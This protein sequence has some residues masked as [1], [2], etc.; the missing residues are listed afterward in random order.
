MKLKKLSKITKVLKRNKFKYV[1]LDTLVP[2]D[3]INQKSSDNFRHLMFTFNNYNTAWALRP[4]LTLM[5]LARYVSNK[6]KKREKI[7]YEGSVFRQRE[8]NKKPI[9]DQCGFEIIGSKNEKKDDAEVIDVAIKMIN[10]L[11]IKS[12]K[13]I[14][15]NTNIFKEFLYGI[16]D[17]NERWA[18][19][20]YKNFNNKE[21]FNELLLRLETSNDLD[22]KVIKHDTK[23]YQK[24]KNLDKNLVIGR[25]KIKDIISRFEKK[26]I[27]DPR[28][29]DQGKKISKLIRDFIIISKSPLKDVEKK[30]IKFFKSNKIKINLNYIFPKNLQRVNN[31]K[32][33]F[34]NFRTLDMYDGLIFK[35]ESNKKIIFSGGRI[36]TSIMNKKIKVCGGAININNL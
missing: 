33:S 9:I 36:K 23:I 14:I 30:L 2:V 25:R 35:I 3:L 4:D 22:D 8:K 17:L 5:S 13:L 19:R 12:A 32:T 10:K 31:I 20:L 6:T 15:G 29:P 34:E 27:F 28:K 21:Y 24:L 7:F 26:T 18:S 16:E 1:D 11:K